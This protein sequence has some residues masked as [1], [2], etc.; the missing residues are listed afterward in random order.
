MTIRE[1]LDK[2]EKLKP[3]DFEDCILVSWLSDLD[4]AIFDEVICTH[5]G[6][7]V[8]SFDGYDE[9]TDVDATVLLAK[10][11]DEEMYIHW[12]IAKIEMHY[13]ELNRYANSYTLYN[14]AY[15]AFANR[16]NRSH[17]PRRVGHRYF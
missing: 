15:R 17:A 10:S 16:Y 2:V 14:Q 1:C 7:E 5:E 8:E 9:G 13:G 11:P 4:A 6:G 3:N 12:L